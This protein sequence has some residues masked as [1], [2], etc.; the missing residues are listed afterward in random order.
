MVWGT[1]I[2]HRHC[3]GEDGSAALAAL[4]KTVESFA[5]ACTVPTAIACRLAI[6]VEELVTNVVC[7][8]VHGRDIS[9][10]MLLAC[11]EGGVLVTLDDDSDPFDPRSTEVPDRPHPEH[12][13]GVGLALVRAWTEITCY[14]REGDR[15]RLVLRLRPPP[16]D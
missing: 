2:S 11:D 16:A 9:M 12:G 14:E 13:G 6:V 1:A 5:E 15:N 4:M 7:H 8:A 10:T 3:A